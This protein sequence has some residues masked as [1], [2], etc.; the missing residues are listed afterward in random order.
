MNIY[1]LEK[2]KNLEDLA[3]RTAETIA[4]YIDLAL[5]QKDRCQIALSG[6][7]TPALAYSLLGKEHLP[8][9]RV[10]L[11][12]GDERW[13]H[14]NDQSSN[15]G[16]LQRTLLS[17]DPGSK[18]KFHPTPTLELGSPEK[19][20]EKFESLIK[21]ICIGEPQVFDLIVLAYYII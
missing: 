3:K 4:S 20:A 8:W 18:A 2:S 9:D 13:V 16:M 1:K 6:G 14:A 19:S 7:K 21:Q 12:L 11:F 17:R 10:D 15:Q 5:S